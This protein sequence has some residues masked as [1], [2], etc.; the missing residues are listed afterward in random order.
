VATVWL[1][2]PVCKVKRKTHFW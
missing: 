2:H 1:G